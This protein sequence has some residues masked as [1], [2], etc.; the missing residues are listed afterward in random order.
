M[1]GVLDKLHSGRLVDGVALDAL[2]AG[3][4]SDDKETRSA[5]PGVAPGGA[6]DGSRT[7]K[8]DIRT[9]ALRFS[10]SGR[11]WVAAT[12][13]GLQVGFAIIIIIDYHYY[14]Y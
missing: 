11:E 10:A 13:L 12:T 6:T 2:D 5:L 4:D 9:N 3:S 7:T 14:Y 8:P 1:E